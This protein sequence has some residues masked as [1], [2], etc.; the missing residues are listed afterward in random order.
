MTAF[1][2][3]VRNARLADGRSPRY[4]RA[5][6][7]HRRRRARPAVGGPEIDAGDNLVSPPFV[8]AHFHMDTTLSLGMPRHNE[9]GTL[10]EG[11]A[12]WGEAKPS[13]PRRSSPSARSPIATGRWRAGCWRSAAM[14]TSAIRACWRSTRCSR[15]GARWRRISTCSSWP[16]RR[17]AICARPT[18]GACSIAALDRGVEVVGGIPHFER[19]MAD[20]A[21]SVR[22]LCELA[23]QARPAGRHALRRE[24][25]SDV[26]PCRDARGR[27]GAAAGCRAG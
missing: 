10:L 11:I 23:A 8:D 17:T 27:D 13:S 12:L 22:L 18:R 2:L 5:A 6:G 20:G 21:E 25:R 19:T 3:I 1:D 16:S 26:A 4:R 24:R 7:P 15:S 9:S 14:S